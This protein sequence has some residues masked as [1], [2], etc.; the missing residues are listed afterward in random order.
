MLLQRVGQGQHGH[1]DDGVH[2]IEPGEQRR[3]GARSRE[4]GAAELVAD[5]PVSR[6]LR[7]RENPEAPNPVHHGQ[8]AVHRHP[9]VSHRGRSLGAHRFQHTGQ[10]E[11]IL[12]DNQ[13]NSA[14]DF[15]AKRP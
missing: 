14:L 8:Q 2:R 7:G 3:S 6:K 11:R 1:F 10:R 13:R 9:S 12:H 15:Q 4:W 5:D